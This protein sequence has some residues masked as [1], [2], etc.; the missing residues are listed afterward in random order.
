MADARVLFQLVAL[1]IMTK[2]ERALIS[3]SDKSGVLE[4]AQALNAMGVKILSTGGTA[5][6]LSDAGVPVTEVSDYTGFPEMLDGRVKTLHPKVH[7]G[8]LGRRDLPEHVAKMN[9]HGI[10]N[11]DLVCVNLYPFEAT[12]SNPDCTLEEAIE[13][14]D[15]GGPT[16]VRSAAKNWAH[17]AVVTDAADYSTLIG[18]MRAAQGK[19]SRKTR[20]TLARKAFT[21]TAAY[22]GAI[23]NYLTALVDE[24]PGGKME[25]SLFPNRLNMQFIKTQDMRYGENPH[26]SAAF[27]RDLDP[28]AGTIAHYRQLQGKEL[29]FN[30][31]GD[32]DAAWEAVK[33]FDAPACVIVKHANPCGV[34]VAD[35]PLSAYR[36]AFA[37]DTTSAFGGIIAFNREVD[38]ETV[39]AVTGQFLEVLIAPS[40]TAEAKT[41]IAAKK[42]VRVLEVPVETGA[43]R[44]ELKRVGGG[45]LVQTPDLRNVQLDELRVVTRRAPDDREMSDL[46]FAWRVA[47]F[48]KSNAIV[49]AR[50][51]QTAG[52][53]A[54]Q[55]SRVDSTRIAARK[56]QEAGL[57]LAGAAAA[58]DAFFPFRDGV[59]VIAEQG[60]KAIIQPGGSVRD[61]EVIAAADE[62]GIAMVLTGCRHFRH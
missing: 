6:L 32:A 22:D 34:A 1:K 45:L 55:M 56:A 60:I 38:G 31:I 26:Q 41:L 57:T 33:T 15:I 17:V 9:E 51:G 5:R 27:Y 46:L 29:S 36:L 49:F 40:F 47:K 11:I 48:V 30:N 43:N 59:D 23:S 19:L 42:N 53:G 12:I 54:G 4:F 7:G 50:G 14:I 18:E 13:N 21:H 37:T 8:I 28:A 61:E 39:E 62:H 24:E 3:V 10:K 16:M 25:R 2:I 58:S 52:I 20:F 44:F 35:K